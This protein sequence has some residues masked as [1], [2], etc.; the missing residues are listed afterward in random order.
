VLTQADG[1][2]H[3]DP[4]GINDC[5]NV[6]TNEMQLIF[7]GPFNSHSCHQKQRSTTRKEGGVVVEIVITLNVG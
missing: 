5:H 2:P 6:S 3:N 1:P 4:I 7:L